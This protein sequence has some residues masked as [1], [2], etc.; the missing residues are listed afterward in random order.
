LAVQ[1]IHLQPV[2]VG[3]AVVAAALAWWVFLIQ[4]SRGGAWS[5]MFLTGAGTRIPEPL[6]GENI[7]VLPGSLGYDGQYYH[8]IA[9]DPWLT[10]G[11]LPSVDN[12]PLRWRRILV[13]A[14]AWSLALGRDEWID[15]AFYAV[16]FAFL[17]LGAWWLA[18]YFEA[19]GA[20]AWWGLAFLLAPAALITLDRIVTDLALTALAAGFLYYAQAGRR[21]MLWLVA[22]AAVLARENGAALAAGWVVWEA[23]GRRFRQAFVF[24]AAVLP[25]LAWGLYVA[26]RTPYYGMPGWGVSIPP[27]RLIA[28]LR[29]PIEYPFPAPVTHFIQTFDYLAVAGSVA[30]IV[31]GVAALW[32]ARGWLRFVLGAWGLFGVL[33]TATASLDVFQDAF[34]HARLLSPL[35]LLL[36]ADGA[37]RRRWAAAAPLLLTAPRIAMLLASQ[38][39]AIARGLY[40]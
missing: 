34:S 9:H 6:R 2:A 29:H 18:R 19:R 38:G 13:S 27:A 17:F 21:R 24:A 40:P 25:A 8:F 31:W 26:W 10:R 12:P 5:S 15:R 16:L 7:R 14:L 23:S 1:R 20:P 33:L 39:L 11:F 3:L 4:G 36:A 22:A 28:S 30:A 37:A 35:I 32:R